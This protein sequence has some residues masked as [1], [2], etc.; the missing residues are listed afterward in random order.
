[1]AKT[2]KKQKDEERKQL[3]ILKATYQMQLKTREESLLKGKEESVERIDMLINETLSQMSKIDPEF[4]KKCVS[5][6]KKKNEH[7]DLSSAI[8][9]DSDGKNIFDE[10]SRI[11]DENKDYLDMEELAKSD[12]DAFYKAFSEDTDLY[13]LADSTNEDFRH[14]LEE[15]SNEINMDESMYNNIDPNAQ[16]DIIPLPSRGECYK[17]K[18]DR[19]PVAYLTASD[20][21]LITSPNLYESGSIINILLKKKIL[22]KDIDVDS[23]VS[24]DVDAIMVFLRGTSYGNNFPITATDPKS[25]K[26]ID[27][28]VDLSKLKYRQFTLK[29]DENGYFDFTLP[30][31]KNRL[32]FKF[33][34]KKDEKLLQKLNKN[35]NGNIISFDVSDA[36]QKIKN[37]LQSDKNMSDANRNMV[38]DANNKLKKWLDSMCGGKDGMP[39]TKTVTNT[40]EMQIVSIN[41]NTDRDYIHNTVMNMAAS[42]SL[43]FRRYVYD[44][45]PGVNFEVE[46]ERPESMGG[47][48]FKCF[49][50]WDDYVF[51]HIS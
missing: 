8:I 12:S 21:N 5:D 26:K 23:L 32:K 2:G 36:I 34:T 25:G 42:D 11:R 49:L 48:S 51:W 39:Y 24:G 18:I 6:E 50:E 22:N 45:Q 14:K 19:I 41:G 17:N 29:G 9:N 28:D 30:R 47:G 37:A 31:T 27:T 44:N 15:A 3:L 4:T 7:M 35:E 20:E 1:M 40:M 38:I 33:L 43:A 46:V 10:L 16:Y 13:A